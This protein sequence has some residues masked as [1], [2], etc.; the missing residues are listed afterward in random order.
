MMSE[1][2]REQLRRLRLLAMDVDGVLTDGRVYLGPSGE[3]LKAFDSHDGF[4]LVMAL[5]AGI[6]VALITAR[7]SEIVARRAQELGIELVIQGCRDK[8]QALRDLAT[9]Q[10]ISLEQVAYIGDDVLDLGAMEAAGTA[11]AVGDAASDAKA[12]A[13]SVAMFPG[14]RG[15]VREIVEMILRTRGQWEQLIEETS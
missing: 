1:Q 12:A 2:L 3:E 4:G 10:G 14:G 13:D 11:F 15:A 7:R 5:R 9:A 8:G 6:A